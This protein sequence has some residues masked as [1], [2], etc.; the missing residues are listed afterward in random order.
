MLTSSGSTGGGGGGGGDAK[1]IILPNTSFGDII[2]LSTPPPTKPRDHRFYMPPKT[3][4]PVESWTIPNKMPPGRPIVS[5]CNSTRKNI[6]GFI[7][8]HLKCYA[9]QHPLYIKNTYDLIDNRPLGLTAP[10]SNN[11]LSMIYSPMNTK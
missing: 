1:T 5:D 2:K 11:T 8:Y 7:D 10:L 3:H 4:K 9:N 6:A